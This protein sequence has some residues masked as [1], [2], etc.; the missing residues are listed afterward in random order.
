MDIETHQSEQRSN[1]GRRRRSV[2][3]LACGVVAA[4]GLMAGEAGAA[5]TQA[6]V[7]PCYAAVNAQLYGMGTTDLLSCAIYVRGGAQGAPVNVGTWG[8][9]AIAADNSGSVYAR[10]AR[11]W[12]FLGQDPSVRS[13]A[14]RCLAGDQRSCTTWR[15]NIDFIIDTL[16]RYDRSGRA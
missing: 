12:K 13:V 11:G 8:G 10:D 7:A 4:G 9:V 1:G 3:A 2:A 5:S 15:T 6:Q 14:D 16:D